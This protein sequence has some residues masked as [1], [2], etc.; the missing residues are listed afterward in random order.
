MHFAT[1]AIH[2]SI[3]GN[4][5]W[6]RFYGTY[7]YPAPGSARPHA[8]TS[9]QNLGNFLYSPNGNMVSGWGRTLDWDGENRP[10]RIVAADGRKVYFNYWPDGSRVR[11]SIEAANGNWEGQAIYLGP[12]LEWS[13]RPELNAYALTKHVIPEAKRVGWGS[14]ATTYFHHRDHL[15]SVRLVTNSSGAVQKRSTFKAFGDEGQ[16]TGSHREEKGFIGERADAETGL[17]YLNARY[18]DPAIGRFISPDWWAPQKEGVGTNRY[19]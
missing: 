9:I 12:E 10:W 14:G 15:K 17:L 16:N 4:M 2:Y 11:K 19:A 6:A 18:Y 13:F 3:S 5:T 7:S 8:V 1:P